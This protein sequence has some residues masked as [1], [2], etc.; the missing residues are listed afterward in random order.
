MELD[1]DAA[2]WVVNTC[3]Y[4][5]V[6]GHHRLKA[7]QEAKKRGMLADLIRVLLHSV[8]KIF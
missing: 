5:V 6:D 8:C 2:R 3:K 1:I 7:I 4:V